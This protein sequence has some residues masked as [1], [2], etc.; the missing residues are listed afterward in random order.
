MIKLAEIV[1]FYIFSQNLR[2]QCSCYWQQEQVKKGSEKK[3]NI[4]KFQI[5]CKVK[6]V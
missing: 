5:V 4:K 6:L 2:I 1:Q 3:K